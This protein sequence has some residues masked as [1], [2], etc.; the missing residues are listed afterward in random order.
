VRP[1]YRR[2]ALGVA[3]ALLLSPAL[4]YLLLD[5][6]LE[7][8]GGR[9]AVERALADGIGMPVELAGEF[10][11]ML[12]PAIGASGTQLVVG[13]GGQGAELMRSSDYAVSL[14]LKPLLDGQ[15]LIESVRFSDGVFYVDRLPG[16][17]DS[18]MAAP[19][20][21]PAIPDIR[22]LEVLDFDLAETGDE[23]APFRLHRLLIEDLAEDREARFALHLREIGQWQGS[24]RWRSPSSALTVAANGR[25]S[26]PGE[27][28]VQ[29]EALLAG[30][31]GSA[32]VLWRPPQDIPPARLRLAYALESAGV[33]LDG[34]DLAAEYL[35]LSGRGC[36]LSGDRPA[37]HLELS[38]GAID[39]DALPDPGDWGEVGEDGPG[40]EGSPFDL[41]IRLAVA[42]LRKGDTIARD[43]V[44]QIGA[45]PDC[46]S[47]GR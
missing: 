12:W 8:A 23:R 1:L 4:A 33:G 26:W 14:A 24:L 38:A 42:E 22:R 32:D 5:A 17:D 36:L 30:G 28:D 6:W 43:A 20:S 29:A 34:I 10:S 21:T 31:T 27:L 9:R 13:D 40:R 19:G 15:L 45:D 3:I 47:V 25:G 7:S 39:V 44:L 18:A 41:N 35:S 2:L 16:G 11:V 46:R 37:L